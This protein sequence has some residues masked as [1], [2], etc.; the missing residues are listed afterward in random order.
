MIKRFLAAGIILLFAA[1]ASPAQ[2]K[3]FTVPIGSSPSVGPPDARVTLIEFI[4]FQ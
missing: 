1:A 4:D 2:E 3:R